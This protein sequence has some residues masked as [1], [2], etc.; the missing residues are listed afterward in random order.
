[1]G[2]AAVAMPHFDAWLREAPAPVI[3]H[4][5]FGAV[6]ASFRRESQGFLW[7]CLDLVPTPRGL[8]DLEFEA[9]AYGPNIAHEQQLYAILAN[10]EALTRAAASA[11]SEQISG[12][13][14]LEWQGALL[15][16]RA[17]T[18][19]LHFW[20]GG[21][22]EALVSIAFERSGPIDVRFDE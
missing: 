6:R 17:G 18:F 19:E 1:M 22:T 3:D 7:E 14:E 11:I 9:G 10:L 2:A 16:G 5:R 20:C 21:D 15:T 4:R 13:V 12:C 8:A